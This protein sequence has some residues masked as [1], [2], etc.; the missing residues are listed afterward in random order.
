LFRI[1]FFFF[2]SQ[3]GG[4]IRVSLFHLSSFRSVFPRRSTKLATLVFKV[5]VGCEG[6]NPRILSLP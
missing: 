6:I 2:P 3:F 5:D 4:L 1:L